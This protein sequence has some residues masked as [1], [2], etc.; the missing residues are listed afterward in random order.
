MSSRRPPSVRDTEFG[1][2]RSPGAVQQMAP[3]SLGNT[4]RTAQPVRSTARALFRGATDAGGSGATDL[5][6]ADP[7]GLPRPTAPSVVGT[8]RGAAVRWDGGFVDPEPPNG[9]I[10]QP[11]NFAYVA[12][13]LALDVDFS[14]STFGGTLAQAGSTAVTPVGTAPFTVYARLVAVDRYGNRSAYSDVTS[15]Q[16][17][18]LISGDIGERAITSA[19]LALAAVQAEN[20]LNG[21][22]D[23]LKLADGAVTGLK[24]A[25]LSVSV[26]KIVDGAINSLKLADLA[27]TNSKILDGAVS[28]RKTALASIDPNSGT[29]AINA[30]Y[31]NS[32]QA[33]AI[34]ADKIVSDAIIARHI[35]ANTITAD[36]I[37]ANQI[38]A[39]HIVSDAIVARHIVA[40]QVTT[41][42]LAAESVTA[43]K[44]G[45]LEIASDKI[46]ANA[47]TSVKIE[48]DSITGREIGSGVVNTDELNAYAVTSKVVTGGLVRTSTSGQDRVELSDGYV[49]DTYLGV[50]RY[51]TDTIRFVRYDGALAAE[52][53]GFMGD[54]GAYGLHINSTIELGNNQST[55]FQVGRRDTNHARSRVRGGSFNHT[56]VSGTITVNYASIMDN[57]PAVLVVSLTSHWSWWISGKNSSG[58]SISVRYPVGH[59]SAGLVP[60][61]GALVNGYFYAEDVV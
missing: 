58:F 8:M 48:A 19:K 45:A 32:I 53:R 31:A 12:V 46:Q 42:A 39:T 23:S 51:L 10:E 21:V 20:I 9:A 13:E 57:N 49:Y 33:G 28:A 14:S 4:V 24:L 11:A 38:V 25:N 44:I 61:N 40:G 15:G 27:V 55:I 3:G 2:L 22:I 17:I 6:G 60:G 7:T 50:N 26:G 34:S 56:T 5:T 59:A 18:Q 1:L 16:S 29:L 54:I 43:A 35:A 41:E 37:G 52:L 30:V 47:I 36:K